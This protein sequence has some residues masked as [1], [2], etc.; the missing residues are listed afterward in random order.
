MSAVVRQKNGHKALYYV[1][2][3]VVLGVKISGWE[4]G[5]TNEVS[6]VIMIWNFHKRNGFLE[7]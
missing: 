6:P 7:A 5:Y 2:D 3:K 4:Y 1:N